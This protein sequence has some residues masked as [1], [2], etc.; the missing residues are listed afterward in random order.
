MT[1]IK[2]ILLFEDDDGITHL[3]RQAIALE[4]NFKLINYE[5]SD[6]SLEKIKRHNPDAIILDLNLEPISGWDVIKMLRGEKSLPYIPVIMITGCYKSTVDMVNALEHFYADDYILKPFNPSILIARIKA[7]L[8]R[9]EI[10][11]QKKSKSPEI[12]IGG[13]T[14]NSENMSV[15]VNGERAE[16]TPTEFKIFMHLAKKVGNV[17][18]RAEIL[19]LLGNDEGYSRTVDRHV[20]EIRRKLGRYGDKIKSVFGFGYMLER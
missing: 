6:N 12:K 14:V 20:S 7:I 15:Y 19:M 13:I 17:C 18:A 10:T 1:E 8:R 3:I 16:L 9:Q 5:H 11:R 2:K 4:E